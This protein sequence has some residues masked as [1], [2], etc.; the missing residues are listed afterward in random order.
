MRLVIGLTGGIGSGKSTV[1]HFFKGL[2]I[3][4]V[5]A[6][7]VAREVVQKGQPA[8]NKICE[9]FGEDILINDEL[10][11]AKLR[12][13]I[14]TDPVKKRWLNNLLHPII[15]EQMLIHLANATSDYVILEAPL[16]FE[17]NLQQYCD[18]VVVVD[19]EESLQIK[20][21][22]AR[23]NSSK[24]QIKAIIDSQITRNLR[25]QKADF[26]INNSSVSLAELE[27]SV[28]TLDKQLRALQ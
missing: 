5:D 12:Q 3:C 24:E 2:N 17:N 8:I 26:I 15:R 22:C 21:A 11:R 20:R 10:D 23:D 1:S 7:I 18:H 28:I 25:L 19:I 4:V 14:F 9:Y 13:I 27:M 6:D 16:L